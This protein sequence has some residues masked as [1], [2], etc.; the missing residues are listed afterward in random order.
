[1]RPCSR[2][3]DDL[4]VGDAQVLGELVALVEELAAR[5]AGGTTAATVE[6]L[7]ADALGVDPRTSA[8][9]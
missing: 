3:V 7:P 8:T 2:H 4:G 9:A 5:S 6:P 1:V